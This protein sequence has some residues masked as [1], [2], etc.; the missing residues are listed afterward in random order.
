M[1]NCDPKVTVLLPVYNGEKYLRE[2]I[3]S[4]L[5]QTFT[6]FML[7]IIDDGSTDGSA[8]IIRSYDDSRIKFLSNETNLTLITT[9]NKG[10]DASRG[11][12]IARMD[13][14]DISMPDRLAKQVAFMDADPEL[15]ACGS[16]VSLINVAGDITSNIRMPQG[17]YLGARYWLQSPIIHSSAMIRRSALGDLRYDQNS[18]HVEDYDLWFEIRKKSKIANVPRFLVRYRMHPESISFKESHTQKKKSY[19]VFLKHTGANEISYDEF[20][21]LKFYPFGANF[22]KRI[23]LTVKLSKLTGTRYIYFLKE[24][25]IYLIDKVY[26]ACLL[27]GK[28][29]LKKLTGYS[30][31]KVTI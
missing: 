3:E 15:G 19:E 26:N 27:R 6:D 16:W 30:K 21:L 4:I 17:K 5:N 23:I 13:Q 22:I 14:D 10:I 7:L 29:F 18:E 11:E 24:D 25:I 1:T 20:L 28:R 9:L 8:D 2:A 12:Y 31:L